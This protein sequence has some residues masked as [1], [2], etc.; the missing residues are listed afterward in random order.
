MR[1]YAPSRW[2]IM[3]WFAINCHHDAALR[4][5]SL[6]HDAV[7]RHFTLVY[8]V[9]FCHKLPPWYCITPLIAG[10]YRH[11][12][13]YNAY[14]MILSNIYVYI[15]NCKKMHDTTLRHF[16]LVHD[17]VLRH[18]TLVYTVVIFRKFSP[19]CGITQLLA[20]NDRHHLAYNAYTMILSNIY[21]YRDKC[22]KNASSFIYVYTCVNI[23]QIKL[24]RPKSIWFGKFCY[25]IWIQS[26]I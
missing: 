24:L 12:L 15:D 13:S 6:V 1:Y 9:V 23:W 11:Q 14:T 21:V 4:H 10:I 20:G 19:W 5:F 25:K 7:L 3:L 18:F 16:S 17:A 8:T 26:L 2:Y 22:K